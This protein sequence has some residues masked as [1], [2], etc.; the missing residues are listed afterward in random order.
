MGKAVISHRKWILFT[1]AGTIKMPSF[2]F[3]I[4]KNN[5]PSNGNLPMRYCS[6]TASPVATVSGRYTNRTC[7]HLTTS[8][9]IRYKTHL[10]PRDVL[11]HPLRHVYYACGCQVFGVIGSDIC[12]TEADISLPYVTTRC[13]QA[14]SSMGL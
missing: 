11:I 10:L 8:I 3:L 14:S 1:N 6:A 12:V 13:S 5:I 2:P 9:N 4:P 7:H